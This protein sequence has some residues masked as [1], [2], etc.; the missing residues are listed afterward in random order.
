MQVKVSYNREGTIRNVAEAI[1]NDMIAVLGKKGS[2]QEENLRNSFISSIIEL[3]TED[4]E[5][6]FYLVK[7]RS[8][9]QEEQW[10]TALVQESLKDG[11]FIK[12]CVADEY[13]VVEPGFLATVEGERGYYSAIKAYALHGS[14][15]MSIFGPVAW[16]TKDSDLD[17]EMYNA[18]KFFLGGAKDGIPLLMS[19]IHHNST[20]LGT[21]HIGPDGDYVDLG[22]AKVVMLTGMSYEDACD[23]LGVADV[24]I[25]LVKEGLNL[26]RIFGNS[27]VYEESEAVASQTKEDES[28]SQNLEQAANIADEE[29]PVESEEDSVI[30]SRAEEESLLGESYPEADVYACAEFSGGVF[31]GD[32]ALILPEEIYDWWFTRLGAPAG[33]IE[34]DG[35]PLMLVCPAGKEKSLHCGRHGINF[36]VDSG[37]IAAT[38]LDFCKEDYS[39]LSK[40]GALVKPSC[41]VE[42]SY[43]REGKISF[44]LYRRK[45]RKVHV[46]IDL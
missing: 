30:M 45:P 14:L 23:T 33:Y 42:L 39:T 7:K 43:S 6:A 28:K 46:I 26:G 20:Y 44:S 34:K 40:K 35:E 1:S 13:L 22:L 8:V 21:N 11:S 38:N 27:A 31:V 15:Y 24:P 4:Y 3:I 16:P 32:P 25:E 19:R 29:E 41:K 36:P 37:F 10:S 9:L 17:T 12:K 18:A 5:C 2:E